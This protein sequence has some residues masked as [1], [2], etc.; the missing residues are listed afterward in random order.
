[1]IQAILD[2]ATDWAVELPVE[3]EVLW[4]LVSRHRLLLATVT[5]PV[6]LHFDLWD[7]NVLTTV[8]DGAA[9]LSGLVDGERYLFG[10]PMIDFASP[11]LFR[12]ILAEPGNPFVRGY[13]S[14]RPLP[15]D[16]NLRIRCDF[17]QLYL[18]LVMIVEYPSRGMTRATD[19]ARWDLL[20]GLV[21]DIVS[22]LSR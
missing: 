15:V 16:D 19:P 1:M 4:E 21:R 22:R 11:W 9:H 7:G 17:A 8:E 18:Y 12:D 5:T 6:L 2:D 14:V 10:D 3:P 13:Q 20:H